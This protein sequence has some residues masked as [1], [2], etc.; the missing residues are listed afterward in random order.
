MAHVAPVIIVRLL[1][2]VYRFAARLGGGVVMLKIHGM[3]DPVHT[4]I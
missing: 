2:H 4:G 3:G 1:T